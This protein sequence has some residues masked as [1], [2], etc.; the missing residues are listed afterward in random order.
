MCVTFRRHKLLSLDDCLFSLLV[1]IP[2]SSRSNLHSCFKRHGISRLPEADA[3]RWEKGHSIGCFQIDIAEVRTDEGGLH[4]F[5]AINRVCKFIRAE[6]HEK[7]TETIIAKPIRKLVARVPH[8]IHSFLA[9]NRLRFTSGTGETRASDHVFYLVCLERGIDHRPTEVNHPWREGQVEH[10]N[11]TIEEATVKR[12]DYGSN[13][14]VR[15]RLNQLLY[16]FNLARRF[17]SSGGNTT[18]REE[19][20]TWWENEPERFAMEPSLHIPRLN[21]WGSEKSCEISHSPFRLRTTGRKA[22]DSLGIR[23]SRRK[24]RVISPHT[25][26]FRSG[27]THPPER[28]ERNSRQR[29][30][31]R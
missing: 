30:L 14:Q 18:L 21:S 12:C 17:Q 20:M 6:L 4:L 11:R 23:A 8:T 31:L 1:T 5:V 26:P 2:H 19:V 13:Q 3:K 7:E 22:T 24:P 9:D 29:M 28:K 15:K 25:V 10:M 27:A 16:A